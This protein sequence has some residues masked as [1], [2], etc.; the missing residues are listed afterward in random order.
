M[1]AETFS[2]IARTPEQI[3]DL[4][5]GELER[6]IYRTGYYK[7]KAKTLRTVCQLLLDRH[8]GV[9][10][11]NKRN[12][13]LYPVLDSKLLILFLVLRITHLPSALILMYIA[14]LTFLA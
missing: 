7:T 9:V 1:C 5:L 8:K 12:F 10:P 14:S 3:L 2:P 6:I 11:K 13:S 4:D